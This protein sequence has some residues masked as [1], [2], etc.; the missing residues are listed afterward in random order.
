MPRS[1]EGKQLPSLLGAFP[2]QCDARA[3]VSVV[4][5]EYGAVLPQLCL[6]SDRGTGRP[7][8]DAVL[9][10][11]VLGESGL[12]LDAAGEDVGCRGGVRGEA[13]LAVDGGAD[14]DDGVTVG[15]DAQ[16]VR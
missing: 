3:T 4:V 16:R 8:A 13:A 2:R 10:D 9:Q 5:Y 15:V 11:A 14:Q 1:R 7:G 6:H 12:D